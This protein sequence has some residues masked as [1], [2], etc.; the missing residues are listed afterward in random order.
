V[1]SVL[2]EA[3]DA[4]NKKLQSKIQSQHH[5]TLFRLVTRVSSQKH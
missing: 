1:K 4:V 5:L 2:A 3:G